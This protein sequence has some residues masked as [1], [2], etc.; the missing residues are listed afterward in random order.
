MI[1]GTQPLE[2]SPAEPTHSVGTIDITQ[3]PWP[4]VIENL[5]SS[6]ATPELPGL[7]E[8]LAAQGVSEPTAGEEIGSEGIMV[9][10]AW[11]ESWRSL[12]GQG[13][14]EVARW[15]DRRAHV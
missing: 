3:T 5:G 11:P 6:L 13:S 15:S 12:D 9:D 2:E 10:L 8:D 14:V 1:R 4:T 7:L